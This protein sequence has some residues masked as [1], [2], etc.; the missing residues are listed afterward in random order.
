MNLNPGSF[1]MS[2]THTAELWVDEQHSANHTFQIAGA[3]NR[4]PYV[5]DDLYTM[6]E[7][8]VLDARDHRLTVNDIDPDFDPLI[9]PL[10]VPPVH[11]I[12]DVTEDGAFIYTP[13]ANYYGVDG[14]THEAIDPAD[15]SGT[16]HVA[17][18]VN[19][20]NDPPTA[21][22]DEFVFSPQAIGVDDTLRI[23]APGV[24]ANDVD[25]DLDLLIAS[26]PTTL[27]P[28]EAVVVFMTDGSIEIP[29]TTA[30]TR[31]EPTASGDIYCTYEVSDGSARSNR[32]TSRI[33]LESEWNPESNRTEGDPAGLSGHRVLS[34]WGVPRLAR[35]TSFY[36]TE[37]RGCRSAPA[38]HRVPVVQANEH[39]GR[40]PVLCR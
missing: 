36:R 17:V 4:S 32:A 40:D 23:P 33:R 29:A 21:F 12:V 1:A 28:Y 19:P 39:S 35:R 27:E 38:R 16:G 13:K 37:V 26:D 18:L 31:E 10:A 22:D 2:A 3:D 8:C 7:D 5:N 34:A 24:L 30:V 6:D 11:G 15:M 25:P 20:D 14:F 9:A